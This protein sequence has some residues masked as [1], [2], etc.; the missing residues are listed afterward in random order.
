MSW[1]VSGIKF[2]KPNIANKNE[3]RPNC[4]D[5]ESIQ[6]RPE[7]PT[8]ERVIFIGLVKENVERHN[9]AR[10][11]KNNDVYD[12]VQCGNSGIGVTT[13]TIG[14]VERYE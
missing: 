11:D 14:D 2:R 8:W 7:Y 5:A 12:W 10:E 1:A 6:N 13:E 9:E 3:S 4:T